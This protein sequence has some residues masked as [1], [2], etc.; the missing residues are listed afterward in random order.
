[1]H[2]KNLTNI[3]P[4]IPA[5]LAAARQLSF[6]KTARELCITQGAVSHQILHLEQ[7][8]GFPLFHRLARKIML[9]E[10][11]E[12]VFQI[13]HGPLWDLDNEIRSMQQLRIVGTLMVQSQP[14]IAFAW[15]VP[16]LHN[17]QNLYPGIEVHMSCDNN[18][19]NFRT[20]PVDV[21]I[22]YGK[23]DNHDLNVIPLM[24]E[25]LTPVCSPEY[26]QKHGLRS[27]KLETISK[28]TLLH[29][30]TPWAN[31]GFF[32][33]W[34]YWCEAVAYTNIDLRNGYSFNYSALAYIAAENGLGLAMGR[35]LLIQKALHEGRLI[36]PFD[37][38]APGLEYLAAFKRSEEHSQRIQIFIN[39][40]QQ[41]ALC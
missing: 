27:G 13:L 26:A 11:G 12:R 35:K 33:E 24:R 4:Y 10:Y 17:F 41:E 34:Q 29:D 28:C 18:P 30:N 15:L 23:E 31:A 7:Y 16:H 38:E 6:T 39:W 36:A 3:L 20:K 32:S 9:T 21:A 14:S 25:T 2:H 40:L 19:L 1:M 5:F 8:L 22:S 37:L